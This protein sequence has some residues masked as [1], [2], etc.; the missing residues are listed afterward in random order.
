MLSFLKKVLALFVIIGAVLPAQSI[1]L[2]RTQLAAWYPNYA[3]MSRLRLKNRQIT[4]IEAGAFTG[5][6][7]LKSISLAKNQLTTLDYSVFSGLTNLREISLGNYF[8]FRFKYLSD[9]YIVLFS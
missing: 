2:S 9:C 7:N 6:T 5:L 8:F 1:V 3:S 4:S